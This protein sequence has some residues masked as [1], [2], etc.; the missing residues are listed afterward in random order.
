MSARR[1][2]VCRSTATVATR[3]VEETATRTKAR[4]RLRSNGRSPH[5]L[6]IVGS[7]VLTHLRR[8]HSD[9]ST[10][11]G[12]PPTGHAAAALVASGSLECLLRLCCL[13]LWIIYV[14]IKSKPG[15][16]HSEHML[17]TPKK[18][19]PQKKPDSHQ[20]G[21]RPA[22]WAPCCRP[23]TPSSSVADQSHP[24]A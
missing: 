18:K 19:P 23:W 17:T 12:N 5:A 24:S 22:S 6:N 9:V 14:S 21:P 15:T 16:A 7:N 11:H 13:G 2:E 20:R 10:A 4:R 8:L 1:E 3:T